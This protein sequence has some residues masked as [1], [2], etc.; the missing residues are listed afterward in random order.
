[1]FL[2]SKQLWYSWI[3]GMQKWSI[4]QEI[5]VEHLVLL[6]DDK[7]CSGVVT[8]LSEVFAWKGRN[9][10]NKIEALSR[11]EICATFLLQPEGLMLIR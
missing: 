10:E 1:M 4:K 11:M 9:T 3:N 7:F 6:T 2:Y 5:Y 8:N